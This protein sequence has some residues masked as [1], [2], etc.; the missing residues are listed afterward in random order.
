MTE[1][2]FEQPDGQETKAST[3]VDVARQEQTDDSVEF[4][5]DEDD[6]ETTPFKFEFDEHGLG[7][8]NALAVSVDVED[9]Y[10][11]PAVTGSSFS[12]FKDTHEFFEEWDDEYD[13]LTEPT[14]R[15]LDL[16]DELG[17]TATFFVVADVVDN[18]PG[19]IEKIAD[20][21]HEIGCHGL[22]HECAIDP[23][24]KEPRFTRDKYKK[25]IGTA[26]RKLEAAT[27]QEVVGFRAPNAYV[28]G[29]VLDVLEELGFQ[30]DSSVA[31]N[32]L[33][34]KTDQELGT[35]ETTPYTPQ[36]GSLDPGGNRKLVE[37]PWPYYDVKLGKIPAAG[38]PLIRL[39]GRRV[40]QAGIEQS[41]RRGDSIF[42]FHPVD[43]ARES[44]PKVGNTRRRPAYWLAKGERAERRIRA[45]LNRVENS[46]VPCSVLGSINADPALTSTR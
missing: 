43:I 33:Y 14:H 1:S 11:V 9:W 24:T 6:I 28:G 25:Q 36:Q 16:F 31:R 3:G 12:E 42:Y 26:K 4:T 19:L 8:Q 20:R 38:G 35:I 2:E 22:H 17:I 41:L 18:Y 5:Y 7:D 46:L 37:L 23:D 40:V 13:Y 27:G 44:F 45:V 10:H 30:Y 29:W 34:N 39:F 32:S 21:G 15:T